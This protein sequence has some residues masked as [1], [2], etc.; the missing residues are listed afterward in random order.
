MSSINYHVHT[1]EPA[2]CTICLNT[3]TAEVPHQVEASPPWL[4]L[5]DKLSQ[6]T[7]Q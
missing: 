4:Q 3:V 6:Q 1:P 5:Q 2:L 7:L